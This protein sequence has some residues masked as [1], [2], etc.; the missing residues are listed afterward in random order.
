MALS[1]PNCHAANADDAQF[2]SKCGTALPVTPPAP[3][4]PVVAP[5]AAAPPT[6]STSA[7]P[8]VPPT[9]PAPV[10]LPAPATPPTASTGGWTSAPPAAAAGGPPAGG[11]PTGGWSRG[12]QPPSGGPGPAVRLTRNVLIGGLLAALLLA[13][14]GGLAL[15]ALLRPASTTP[16]PAPV[17]VLT[18]RPTEAPSPSAVVTP[19]PAPTQAPAS[20]APTTAPTSAPTQ[21]PAPTPTAAPSASGGTGTTQTIDVDNISVIVP[22]SW[23]VLST[24]SYQIDVFA[25][26]G[27]LYL[28]SGTVT[29]A[30][31]P[32]ED[33]QSMLDS[34]KAKSP[35][36]HLCSDTQD[37]QIPNG[38]MG[39]ET[40]VCYTGKTNSGSSYNAVEFWAVGASDGNHVL[41]EMQVYSTDT[42]LS[43]AADEIV[44]VFGDITWK[45]WTGN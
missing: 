5:A 10:T 32:D 29:D 36:A 4:A 8:P 12:G 35:D 30:V 11:S 1:C 19:T 20:V 45:L 34:V 9:L 14:V 7:P 41:Y 28:A 40:H 38:P 44:P 31:T 3:P 2:C 25:T 33:L 43:A 37:Y 6:A 15:G 17:P 24:E 18:P 27:G 21:T 26:S 22:S 16:T 23:T 39:R 13:G 42:L